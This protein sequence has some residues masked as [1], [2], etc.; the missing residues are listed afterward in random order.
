M[1]VSDEKGTIIRMNQALRDLLKIKDE[2]IIGKYNVLKDIQVI[3]QGYL[4]LVQSVFEE[5]K[6]V[7]FIIDYSTAQEKQVTLREPTHKVLEIVI[8]AVRNEK[9]K[10]IHAIAQESDITERK[11]AEEAL[12][13]S[14]DK[15]SKAFNSSPDVIVISRLSDGKIIELNETGKIF[16]GNSQKEMLGKSSLALNLLS[17]LD[18]QHAVSLL[19][20][21]GFVRD[22]ELEI[23]RKSGDMRQVSM[24]IEKIEIGGEQCMLTNIHDITERQQMITRINELNNIL[25]LIKQINQLIVQIDNEG[26]LLQQACSHFVESRQ[27]L[28]AWIGFVIR[29]FP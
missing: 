17:P 22:F 12:R 27:Y 16:W 4:P 28:L 24:S 15:F 18:R 19:E 5:G 6:T 10:V 29:G 9:G 20:K 21:Q 1:W 26:E 23:R 13:Q 3:E 2:E 7:H 25:L 8:S 11:E 14:E